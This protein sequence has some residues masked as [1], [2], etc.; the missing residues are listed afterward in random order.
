MSNE[1]RSILAE[2]LYHLELIS[3]P[4]ISPGGQHVIFVKHRVDEKTEKKY[5]NLWMTSSSNGEARQF[6][7]GDQTDSHPR[8]SPD[9]SILAFLSNRADV[10]KPPQIFV[11]PFNGGEARQLTDIQGSITSFLWSPNGMHLLC[12]IRKTDPDVIEREKDEQKKKLGVVARHY[13]RVFYKLDG[14]GY[15]PKERL[16]LWKVDSISG[17]AHQLTDSPIFDEQEPAWSPDGQSIVFLS[18]RSESP[19]FNPDYVDIYIL[20]V[21]GGEPRKV[22]APVGH[23]SLPNYSPDAKWIA[24]YAQEGEAQGYKNA[25]LWIVPADG[26]VPPRNL[27]EKYDLHASAWTINDVGQPETMPPTW[28]NDGKAIYFQ[29]VYHG[30]TVLKSISLDGENLHTVVGEGGV[31]S[32]YTFD[33]AQKYLAYFYGTM[34]D[35]GQ[36]YIEDLSG[37]NRTQLTHLNQVFHSEVDLGDMLKKF[38][39]KVQQEMISRVGLLSHLVLILRRNTLLFWRSTGDHYAIWQI[40]SC[41]SSFTW[42]PKVMLC[43]SPT[44]V[45]DAVMV[46]SMQKQFGG[47]G[48]VRT[49]QT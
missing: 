41:T 44:P 20:P 42:H 17:E 29:V 45:E 25:G 49:M 47:V 6:T 48:E 40:S 35:P 13:D 10:E 28:S 1:K 26:S 21:N 3:E 5:S 18:N 33:L 14:L 23:K 16:H 12:N 31:V 43:I 36:I 11:I 30:S 27:T 32:A 46:R 24:Y 9:G 8:W 4:R 2:D 39:S 15:L 7:F 34:T 37:K 19:D 38:G 22:E